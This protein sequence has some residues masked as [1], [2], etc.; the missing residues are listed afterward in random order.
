MFLPVFSATDLLKQNFL[1]Q[2]KM[3][4][5]L[6][7]VMVALVAAILLTSC[8]GPTIVAT[9]PKKVPPGQMKKATGS[10]SAK[11]YAPGQQKKKH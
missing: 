7:H 11:A 5:I 8:M 1:N 2:I 4:R 3:K 10:Q 6:S 9:S